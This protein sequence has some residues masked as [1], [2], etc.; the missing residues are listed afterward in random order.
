MGRYVASRALSDVGCKRNI[1][2]L[3]GKKDPQGGGRVDGSFFF[4][5]ALMQRRG[6]R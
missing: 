5:A 6:R 3:E 2:E 4:E 1:I